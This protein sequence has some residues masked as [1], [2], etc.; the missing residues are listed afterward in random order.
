VI[1]LISQGTLIVTDGTIRL[2]FERRETQ[3][4]MDPS[5]DKGNG[6]EERPPIQANGQAAEQQ[7]IQQAPV[8]DVMGG[9]STS[10]LVFSTHTIPFTT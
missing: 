8:M 2:F 10:K 6:A 4:N 1:S 7:Q 9:T 3:Q 5:C